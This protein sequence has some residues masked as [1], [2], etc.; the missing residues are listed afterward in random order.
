M[1][2]SVSSQLAPPDHRGPVLGAERALAPDLIRGA[3]LLMIALANAANFAFAGSPGLNG[4][5]H[6]LE[7]ILNF[8]KITLVDAR[9]YPVFAV[10]FGYGLV[11]LT[12]RQRKS[13]ATPSAVRKILLKRHTWMIAFGLVHATLLYFGDFLGAYGIV[14]ILCT[15]LLLNR[16]DK[17]HKIVLWIWGAQVVYVIVT[18]ALAA[19]AI[20]NPSSPVHGMTNS[21]NPSLGATSYFGSMV[22]RLHEW[23]SHTAFVTGFTVI[24]WLGIWAARKQ[25]LENPLAHRVLLT[26]VA[27]VCMSIVV[28]GGLPLAL[29]AAGWLQVDDAGLDSMNFLHNI[30]G[31]FGGPGYVALWALLVGKL[32]ARRR[33]LSV[34]MVAVSALGQR[35]MTGYLFQSVSWMVLLAP[36]TLHL[37]ARLG[38]TA[39]TAAGAAI[40][41]WTISVIAA[42]QMKK[43]SYRGPAE[44][45][46]RRLTY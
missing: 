3:M 14:G 46:L 25:L 22:D 20:V 19:L 27:V 5:P 15:L 21:P 26:R 8:L 34:P 32:L 4:S 16:G 24:V 40:V 37:G 1:T 45:L 9:A 13:G 23:P 39:F 2:Q 44:T 36:F 7:R 35:S 18:G 43:R 17:F 30:S 31:Q 29:V 10:M 33:P 6:G 42:Y 38:N 12:R 28:L 11:Q 41:V